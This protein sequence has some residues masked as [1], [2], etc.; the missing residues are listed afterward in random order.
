MDQYRYMYGYM[1]GN[2]AYTCTALRAAPYWYSLLRSTYTYD[3]YTYSRNVSWR[4][5]VKCI[6]VA[7]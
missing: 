4:A 2:R 1:Y 6:P 3:S 5:W 7:I